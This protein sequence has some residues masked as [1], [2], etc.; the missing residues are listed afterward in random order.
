VAPA[1][2]SPG[3]P[4]VVFTVLCRKHLFAHSP[5]E[6]RKGLDAKIMMTRSGFRTGFCAAVRW[7][8]S[9]DA[10]RL[11]CHADSAVLPEV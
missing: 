4:I 11:G 7:R 10:Q 5:L 2:R 3:W 9:D 8:L 1:R 6:R